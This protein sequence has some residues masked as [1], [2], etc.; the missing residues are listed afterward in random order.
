MSQIFFKNQPI[1]LEKTL[2]AK[3]S[4]LPNFSFTLHNL[5]DKDLSYFN[6]NKLILWF[7]PSLDTGTCITS[8]K[9][10]NEHLKKHPSTKALI[11]SMDLPFA[12][13]RICGLEGLNHVTVA[14]LFRHPEALAHL[15][16]LIASSP[17]KGLSA[18]CVMVIDAHH[19]VTYLDLVKEITQEP[20]YTELF[21]FLNH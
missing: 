19:N 21:H 8:A 13:H 14:S 1:N 10:L 6:E 7:V 18:R 9:H 16:I 11:L 15:G 3:G 17:L 5:E 20:N 4:H 2:I 12:Q